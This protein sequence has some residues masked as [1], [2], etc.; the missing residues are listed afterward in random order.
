MIW[1]DVWVTGTVDRVVIERTA[2]G[3]ILR[4]R[5]Y[6]FKTDRLSTE[7]L[8]A[9]V[10]KHDGQMQLYRQAVARLTGLPLSAV[11]AWVVFT[12]WRRMVAAGC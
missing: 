2:G 6:D 1:N 4:A 12:R 5:I 7:Q 9:A 11:E 10:A 8:N 3:E